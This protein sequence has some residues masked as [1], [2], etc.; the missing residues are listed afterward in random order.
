MISHEPSPPPEAAYTVRVDG[1]RLVCEGPKGSASSVS[2]SGLRQ[3]FVETNDSG[4]WGLDVWFVLVDD[5]GACAYPMGATGEQP[6]LD[7]LLMLP[8]FELKGMN[9]TDN[10]RFLCWSADSGSSSA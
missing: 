8:G 4:P 5:A 6:A 10:A 1:D 2:F 3:V 9:S 7:R